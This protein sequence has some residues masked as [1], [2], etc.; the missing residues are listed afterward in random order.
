[1]IIPLAVDIPQDRW[2]VM[3]WLIMAV[4]IAVFGLQI[5]QFIEAVQH[6]SHSVPPRSRQDAD[7]DS[8]ADEVPRD[9]AARVIVPGITAALILDGWS[10]KRQV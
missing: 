1:V 2:P 3:N 4:T 6:E 5:H 9:S 10:L 7:R 8:S